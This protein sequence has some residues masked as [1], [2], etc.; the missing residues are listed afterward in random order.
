MSNIER[1]YCP[2]C[3][4]VTAFYQ[5]DIDFWECDECGYEDYNDDDSDV[6]S[7]D[8]TYDDDDYNT[9]DDDGT[10]DEDDGTDISDVST[11]CL[12]YT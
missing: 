11:D 1:R 4:E 10:D 6:G 7:D 9:D 3:E 8:D 12:A 2:C 5:V